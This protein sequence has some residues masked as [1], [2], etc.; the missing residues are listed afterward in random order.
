MITESLLKTVS[1]GIVARDILEDDLYVD[2]YPIEL[3]P[4]RDG[5]LTRVTKHKNV[6]TD[7]YDNI[8]H[9]NVTQTD[10]IKA[11]WLPD[12]DT[13]RLEPP[14]VCKGETVRLLRYSDTDVYYWTTLYN[15]LELRKLE[16]RTMV[17]SNKASILVPV[18]DLL[19]HSYY[20]TVDTINKIV[21]LHTSTTDGEYTSYDITIDTKEGMLEIT[22]GKGN[23][24]FLESQDDRMTIEANKEIVTNTTHRTSNV[25]QHSQTNV[26]TWHVSNGADELVKTLSDFVQVVHDSVGDGNL[27]IP[28]PMSSGTQS[29][30]DAI[31]A[32]LDGFIL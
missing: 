15:Q 30:L 1:V 16:K 23:R 27:G 8:E 3:H 10:L 14:T 9:L 5:E 7:T 25:R 11:R 13:N 31:K 2:V 24:I 32:R 26:K 19:K 21:H 29:A 18:E 4:G 6:I 12:G 20:T 17:V 22:D 28:V